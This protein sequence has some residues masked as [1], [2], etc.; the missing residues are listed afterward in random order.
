MMMPKK[1]SA[2]FSQDPDVGVNSRVIRELRASH[3]W[4]FGCLWVR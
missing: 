4:T 3:A 2:M 1:I